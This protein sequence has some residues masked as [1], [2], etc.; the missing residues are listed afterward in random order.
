MPPEALLRARAAFCG[1]DQWTPSGTAAFGEEGRDGSSSRS[2]NSNSSSS[3][4]SSHESL[5]KMDIEEDEPFWDG[6]DTDEETKQL[7]PPAAA[8]TTTN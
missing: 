7:N 1:V 8:A 5:N 4:S 3:S 2:S 6:G